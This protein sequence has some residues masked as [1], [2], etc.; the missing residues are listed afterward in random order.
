MTGVGVARVM[1]SIGQL[2]R[3]AGLDRTRTGI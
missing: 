3:G 1:S 2:I